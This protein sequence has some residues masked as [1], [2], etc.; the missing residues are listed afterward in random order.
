[1]PS[2]AEL[3]QWFIAALYFVPPVFIAVAIASCL[4]RRDPRRIRALA[5]LWLLTAF[6]VSTAYLVSYKAPLGIHYYLGDTW[7]RS[8]LCEGEIR[9]ALFYDNWRQ[10]SRFGVHKIGTYWVPSDSKDISS[11]IFTDSLT[12][13]ERLEYAVIPLWLVASACAGA[14]SVAAMLLTTRRRWRPWRKK[15]RCQTCNYD[16]SACTTDRCPECG[17]T[18]PRRDPP[19]TPARP[20]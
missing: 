20:Y 14:A 3:Y 1:M 2:S 16:I 19:A 15:L 8:N 4:L 9:T 5:V 11:A 10:R 12:N 18:I 6:G 13:T 7:C 17:T